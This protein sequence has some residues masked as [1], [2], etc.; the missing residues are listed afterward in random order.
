MGSGGQDADAQRLGEQQRI[1]RLGTA[2]GE[3]FVRMDKA[4]DGQ[5]VN[6]FGAVD[7]VSACND[8][9]RLIDLLVTTPQQLLNGAGVHFFRE[10][11]NVQR[12]LGFT[13]H[14]IHVAQGVGSGNLSI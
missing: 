9:P 6:G 1:S 12:Q 7:G 13:A 8:G 11:E 3:H 4:G 2:V 5:A 14:G 10:T